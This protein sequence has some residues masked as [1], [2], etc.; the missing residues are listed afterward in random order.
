MLPFGLACQNA[1]TKVS[2]HL[3]AYVFRSMKLINIRLMEERPVAFYCD[4]HSHSRKHNVFIY[5]CEDKELNE[6]PL[7]EQIFPLMMHKAS[8][9]KVRVNMSFD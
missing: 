9:G 2:F 6:V 8:N 7:I 3:T 1:H 5:G 4:F